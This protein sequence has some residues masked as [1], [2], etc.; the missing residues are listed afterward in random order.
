MWLYKSYACE[1]YSETHGFTLSSY[2]KLPKIFGTTEASEISALN[3]EV[4]GFKG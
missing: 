4:T 1:L 2:W 3:F